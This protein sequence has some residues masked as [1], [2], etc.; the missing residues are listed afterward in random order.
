MSFTFAYPTGANT[1]FNVYTASSGFPSTYWYNPGIVTV[2]VLSVVYS[3]ISSVPLYNLNFAPSRYSTSVFASDVSAFAINSSSLTVLS[4][5]FFT[6]IICKL[7]V[8]IFSSS[9]VIFIV[10][11]PSVSVVSWLAIT[12]VAVSSCI[13]SNV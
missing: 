3:P 5:V 6:F 2:P 13:C 4:V 9:N 11:I 10:G 7:Y 12:P 1:S 8:G